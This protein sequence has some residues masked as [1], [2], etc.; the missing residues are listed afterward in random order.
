M[1]KIY[2]D[3]G[4]VKNHGPLNINNISINLTIQYFADCLSRNARL[5]PIGRQCRFWICLVSV[6]PCFKPTKLINSYWTL[7]V[8]RGSVVNRAATVGETANLEQ[9]M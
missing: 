4:R 2:S 7:S 9:V 8:K 6:R 3:K 5:G 1:G